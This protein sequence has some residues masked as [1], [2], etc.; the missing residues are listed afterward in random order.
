MVFSSVLFLFYF[1][2]V[3][4]FC[5]FAVR[6]ELRNITLLCFSLLFYAWGE[7]KFIFLLLLSICIN[8]LSGI[9]IHWFGGSM[10]AKIILA[11]SLM[12]NLGIL[13]FYKYINFGI[14]I[15][16]H[17]IGWFALPTTIPALTVA[18]PIGLSFF[19]FQGISYVIDV[20]R[21]EIPVQ[22]N[23]FYVALYISLFP[24]LVA[25]P[26][27]R[28]SDIYHEFKERD[29]SFDDIVAGTKRFIIGLAKKVI[30]A[31]VLA[32]AVDPIFS[33]PTSQLELTT[34]WL[35]AIC[36]TY[37][38]FFEFS[39]YSEMAIGIGRIFGFHFQENFNLPYIST[40][41]REFWRRWHISLS[42]WFRDYLYI[43]LG[44]NRQ[45]N[46]YLNLFIVF[47]CTGLWHGAAFTFLFWGL[48]HGFF[49]IAERIGKRQGWA[50]PV[51]KVVRWL[52][53]TLVVVFGWVLF[54]SNGMNHAIA[55]FQ[56]MVG[57]YPKGFRQ[58][59]LAYYLNNHVLFTLIVALNVSLGIPGMVFKRLENRFLALAEYSEYL[60]ILGL[61]V[62]LFSSICMIV[63]GNYSPF[64]YFRF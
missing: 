44:G 23:P 37:Q 38:I 17:I 35:G 25:G 6:K 50:A 19:T 13:A 61:W 1:F 55:Y 32:S 53:T 45:G 54:R 14:S 34:A 42:S 33:L 16:N 10:G 30:I 56:A 22:K 8:Y 15:I 7:P 5:Y 39:G 63:N 62:L 47:I 11:A 20:Y 57:I 18:L 28:Y 36:N 60:R 2:P 49:L 46:T 51:P 31:D 48:W 24:Q 29:S 12:A 58:F 59:G 9:G 52:Y 27:V 40:S 21:K 64:I 41:V 26:I 43:P 4:L 3:V